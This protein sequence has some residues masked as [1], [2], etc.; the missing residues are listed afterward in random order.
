M[1]KVQQL[2][3]KLAKAIADSE[4][5]SVKIMGVLCSRADMEIAVDYCDR[6]LANGN[7]DGVMPPSGN[8]K[9]LFEKIKL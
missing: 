8:V 7:L 4:Y 5:R 6:Y 2:K 3:N 9:A 1:S